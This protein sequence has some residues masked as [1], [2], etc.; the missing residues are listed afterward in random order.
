[1]KRLLLLVLAL[2]LLLSGCSVPDFLPNLRRDTDSLNTLSVY[3]LY[4]GPDGGALLRPE[5]CVLGEGERGNAQQALSLFLSPSR[6]RELLC[7]LPEGV[8]LERWQL[9]SGLAVLYFSPELHNASAMDKSALAFGAALTLCAL[10]EVDAVT[11]YAGEE[12][13]FQGLNPDDA[14]L[15]D[16]E[17]DPYTRRLRLYFA[18]SEGR[19]LVSEYHSLS[20]DED[21]SPE[22]Y[23][24]E[25]LLR[26]PNDPSLRQAIPAGTRLLSCRTENGVCTVDLS[27]E[28]LENR[29]DT[30]LGE[31][32]A[33]YSIVNSLGVLSHVDSVRIL[34]QGQPV[35]TYLYRSLSEPLTLLQDAVGP[36]S[37]AKGQQDV[38]L[39][40]PL[41]GLQAVT[42]M[43]FVL[44]SAGYENELWAV[45]AALTEQD[46]P[47]Y[48]R[49][50]PESG[51]IL[52]ISLQ[53]SA[54]TVD[55]AESFFAS[56]SA[57]E[58]SAAVGSLAASLCSLDSVR[59]VY[60]TMN[61]AEAVFEGVVYTGPWNLNNI[62]VIE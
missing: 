44:E 8:T 60:V 21:S 31:R 33:I 51:G 27:A 32:L 46:E 26:G 54:C 5:V 56:L 36:A 24:V 38:L 39:Y 41:P 4:T 59:S 22:R 18:D 28:F 16:T 9:E 30:A 11:V 53:G 43:P 50:F 17:A 19:Y 6:D 62:H 48:P 34:C 20:L 61:G 1:M 7:A 29:P 2:C 10:D 37:A 55:V 42:A 12:L 14:L 57:D 45:A 3:R 15:A 23:V 58:R 47:G 52:N 49:V 35:D 25:E 40:R 13:L